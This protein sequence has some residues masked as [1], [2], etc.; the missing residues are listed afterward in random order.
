M[1][2][3]QIPKIFIKDKNIQQF[4]NYVST[5]VSSVV[6]SFKNLIQNRVV[7]TDGE[8]NLASSIVTVQELEYL[9]GST[10]N[11][12]EQIEVINTEVNSKLT[13][14]V[15][16]TFTPTVTL[17]GGVG[18]TTPVYSTNSGR[19]IQV[20]KIIFVDVLLDGDGGAEGAGTGVINIALPT[21]ASSNSLGNFFSIGTNRNGTD[22][23]M[24]YGNINAS[25]NT[26][27][28]SYF[29]AIANIADLTGVDQNNTT[30]FIRLKFFYE[31]D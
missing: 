5:W 10:N 14:P 21:T 3:K 9:S 17:V 11:I 15:Y 13:S 29:S 27:S 26:I 4:Q 24:L 25:S 12:Q 7:V 1:N 6:E 30:R 8:N 28:I 23:N 20:G 2:L 31:I 16:Q 22:E 18:N 19:Y